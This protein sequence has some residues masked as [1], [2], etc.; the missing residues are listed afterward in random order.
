[1]KKS[2][3]RI[4]SLA[5]VVSML[6]IGAQAANFESVADQLNTLGVF[7][8]T[9][10]GYQLDRAPTRAEAATM[11]VRLLG[12]EEAAKAAFEA[13]ETAHPFTDVA[14]WAAPYVAYLYTEGLTKGMSETAFGSD[15]LCSAQMYA[16]F[17]LRTLGY[18]DAEGGDFTYADAT[19]FATTKGIADPMVLSGDFLRDQMVVLS[20]QTLAPKSKD[21]DKTLLAKLV[22]EG[23][24]DATAA[25]AM[26]AKIDAMTAY[27]AA[28]NA[29]YT[30][31]GMAMD[32]SADMD[33]KLTIAG[34][35]MAMDAAMNVAMILAGEDMQMAMD[36]T[37]KMGDQT[38]NI[39]E[40]MKDGKVYM[41]DGTAKTY[42][43]YASMEGMDELFSQILSIKPEDMAVSGLYMVDSITSEAVTGGTKYTMV[44]SDVMNGVINDVLA[45]MPEEM[46]GITM[47]INDL[48]ATIT[49]GTDGALKTMDMTMTMTMNMDALLAAA[50]EAAGEEAVALGDITASVTMSAKI[51]AMGDKVTITFPDFSEFV[52]ASTVT[53]APE[54]APAA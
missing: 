27:A 32:M 42:V 53:P 36:M 37:T 21:A 16:T 2:L 20:Y 3:V 35:E 46:S 1:M 14:D 40:W 34:T 13:E 18:S 38:M 26:T 12:K 24:I 41:D 17:M 30:E 10:T 25:T 50:T 45:T 51:N 8:G 44:Y 54:E 9:A 19:T 33:L 28:S 23:S 47:S 43:D 49:V 5:L 22:E 15:E 39:K 52:D 4:L 29:A 48:T 11:L 6:A 7:Q 31:D